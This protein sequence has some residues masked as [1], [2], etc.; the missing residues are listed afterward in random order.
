MHHAGARIT[1]YRRT[2]CCRPSSSRSSCSAGACASTKLARS[3]RTGGGSPARAPVSDPAWSSC[4]RRPGSRSGST[5]RSSSPSRPPHPSVSI[6]Q[7]GR[8]SVLDDRNGEAYPV[9]IPEEPAWYSRTTSSGIPMSRIGVLQ[10]NYLGVYVSNACLYWASSPSPRLQVLHDRQERRRRGAGAQ[11]GRGRRRGRAGGPRRIGLDLHAPEHGLPLRGGGPARADPR[12]AAVR[13]VRAGAA[14]GG[15]RLHR[16][17]GACRCRG[18][19]S[20]STTR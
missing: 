13:A 18:G 14:P 11:E 8:L 6:R 19:S 15:R 5:S 16:R 17:A 10:G 1:S 20:T 12:P 9:E 7:G 4:S 3:T 2:R